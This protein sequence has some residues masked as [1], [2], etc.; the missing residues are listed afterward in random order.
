MCV[1]GMYREVCRGCVYRRELTIKSFWCFGF[2]VVAIFASFF[3]FHIES[4]HGLLSRVL[5]VSVPHDAM[6]R[7]RGQHL[8]VKA[9]DR[10]HHKTITDMMMRTMRT[11]I[12]TTTTTTMM[13]TVRGDDCAKKEKNQEMMTTIN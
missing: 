12:T 2:K 10:T 6:Q 5:L 13:I 8:F 7:R 3:H 11:N 1:Q 4:K 9:C